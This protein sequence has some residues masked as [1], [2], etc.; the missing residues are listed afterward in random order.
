[1]TS[2][3]IRRPHE[4]PFTTLPLPTAAAGSA[5]RSAGRRHR[6]PRILT[7]RSCAWLV[8]RRTGSGTGLTCFS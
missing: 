6:P 3:H 5:P 2:K 8:D 7:D 4:A 1:L